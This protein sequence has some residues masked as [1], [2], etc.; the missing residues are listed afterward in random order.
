[1]NFESLKLGFINYLEEISETTNKEYITTNSDVSIFMYANEFKNYLKDELNCDT[2]IFSKNINEILEMEIVNGQLTNKDEFIAQGEITDT[3]GI[4]GSETPTLEDEDTE[5]KETSTTNSTGEIKDNN[6][7]DETEL[8]QN[9]LNDL[10]KD[11][12]FISY[13]D[14]D[15]NSEINE[16]ELINFLNSIKNND[17]NDESISLEDII[18]ATQE[19][20]D[21]TYKINNSKESLDEDSNE[22]LPQSATIPNN[23]GGAGATNTSGV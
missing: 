23:S 21:G 14:T 16:E 13:I 2:S 11:E 20:Q 9:I 1:M 5:D 8:I 18:I 3:E 17:K 19:M 22:T 10:L 7:S 6:I 12:N 4:D 15:Q